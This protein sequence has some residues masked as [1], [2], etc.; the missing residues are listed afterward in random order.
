MAQ[1]IAVLSARGVKVIA[2]ALKADDPIRVEL[3]VAAELAAAGKAGVVAAQFQ[4]RYG[5]GGRTGG[6]LVDLRPCPTSVAANVAAGP[7]KR[8]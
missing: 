8:E 5:K 3:P 2:I 4:S 7:R 1:D 6:T